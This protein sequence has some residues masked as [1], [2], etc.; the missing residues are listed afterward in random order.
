MHAKR[1]CYALSVDPADAQRRAQGLIE[2]AN[3]STDEEERR[4]AAVAACRLI[5]QGGLLIAKPTDFVTFVGA[6]AAASTKGPLTPEAKR[7]RRKKTVE[8]ATEAVV[9]TVGAASRIV[10]SVKGFQD[11]LNGATRR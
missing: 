6:P 9:D 2:L 5:K 7:A 8:A 10:S 1:A 3:R 4:T 11:A